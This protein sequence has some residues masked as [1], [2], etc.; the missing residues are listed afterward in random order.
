MN[1]KFYKIIIIVIILVFTYFF[2]FTIIK[3]DT[4]SALSYSGEDLARAILAN[5]S[6]LVSSS[7]TDTDTIGNRQAVVLSSFGGFTPTNGNTFALFSTGIAGTSIIT[8]DAQNPGDERGTWFKNKNSHPRDSATLTMVLKVP[9]YMHYLYYDVQFFSAEYP[10]YI[11]LQYDDQLTISVYS[12][13]KGNSQFILDVNSGYF[14]LDSNDITGTGFDIFAQSGIPADID[15][16]D[17][18]PRLPGADAGASDVIPIGGVTHPISPNE[19]ITVT[20]KIEDVGDNQIDSAALIDNLMFTGYARTNIIARKTYEDVNGGYLESGD[21]IKYTVTI[22]NSGN[23]N[24]NNNPGNEFEDIIPDNTTYVPG[25]MTATSGTIN[26]SAD[27]NKIT[28]D[29]NIPAE[30]AVSLTFKVIIS[31]G[32]TNGH[33]ISNQG[34][35]HWDSNEDG[36]NDA[37]ELTDD[38]HID[39]GI[40]QDGDGSTDDDDPTNTVVLAFEPPSQVTE[41]FSD[42]PAGASAI[43]SYMGKTWF[44]TNADTLGNNFEVAS[45]YHYSTPNSF[46]TQIRANG[47]KQYW[48]YTLSELQ[49]NLEWWEIWFTCGNNSEE[50]DLY[51]D[52]KDNNGSYV[53][54]LKFEYVHNGYQLPTDWVVAMYYWNPDISGWSRL[55][56][57]FTDGIIYDGYLYGSWYKL[58]IEKPKLSNTIT[59][60]LSRM[61]KGVVDSKTGGELSASFSNL[62][63]IEW[64][65]T[66]N[67]AVC[68]MFFWDEHKIGLT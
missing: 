23:A 6:T 65:S 55:N 43:Q 56:S 7:Y 35:A 34:T 48:N 40:D 41:D 54:R 44:K 29:G 52:F 8:T 53:A 14:V 2:G 49:R 21:T 31:E 60:T 9:L 68:P 38:P 42:E 39:D 18:T 12:P 5:Q 20:I 1:I 37:N 16:V 59:Y 57:D 26:Y 27:T 13:S 24:Q 45:A 47:G 4:A 51:L 58:R 67:P 15:I 46:K 66:K 61:C 17:K 11:G 50:S 62:A 10:E 64:S 36:T 63:S 3:S 33:I 25:S 22:S 19:Q 32:L 30:S 28:W